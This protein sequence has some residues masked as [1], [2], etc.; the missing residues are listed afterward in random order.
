MRD[1]VWGITFLETSTR[2][3][4]QNRFRIIALATEMFY[5]EK[6]DFKVRFDDENIIGNMH[7]TGRYGMLGQYGG[8]RFE[9]RLHTCYGEEN[10]SFLV[11]E[12]G[13]GAFTYNNEQN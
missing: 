9:A 7:N 8:I 6:N 1:R 10:L 4:I 3:S 12:Q 5:A 2:I 13:R 11:S